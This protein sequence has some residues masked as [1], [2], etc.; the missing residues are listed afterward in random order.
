MRQ[1]KVGNSFVDVN[2]KMSDKLLQIIIDFIN[3]NNK[4]NEFIENNKE[5]SLPVKSCLESTNHTIV[6]LRW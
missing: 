4:V 3:L 6:D 1:D 5:Q 2:T